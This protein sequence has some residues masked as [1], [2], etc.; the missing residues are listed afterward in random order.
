MK[1]TIVLTLLLTV[2]LSASVY[3][4]NSK[5]NLQLNNATLL[6]LLQSIESNSDYKFFYNNDEI[7]V[8]R[9]VSVNASNIE[10]E[11]ILKEV[12]GNTPYS[13]KMMKNNLILIENTKGA[14]IQAAGQQKTVS[15]KV[16]DSSGQPLP[17]V[18]VV[19]KGTTTGTITDFDG[20]Y[21]LANVPADATLVFSF[22]G[23]K[24]QEISVS[25]KSS[26]QV[27][28]EED[29]VGIEEVVA[30]GY[31]S[32][33]KK[34]LTSSITTVSAEELN[35]G[36]IRDPVLALQ[37]KVPGL[38]ITK[39]GSP[40]GSASI[41]LR[42]VS[43][44]T[45][46]G[47]PFY[48]VDGMPNALMPAMDDIVSI[49]VLKDASATAIYGSRAANGVIIIT[50]KKGESGKQLISYNSYVGVETVSNSIDMMSGLEYRKY[51]ADNGLSINPED[52]M[53]VNTNWQ[54][55]LTRVGISHKNN[56]SI[57]GGTNKTTYISSIEYY[58]NDGV[59]MGTSYDRINMRGSIEQYGFND[60]LKLQ[61]Q[62]GGKIDNS[63]R[64]IDLEAVLRNM[65]IFQPTYAVR[66][67]DGTYA[68]RVSNGPYN[69]VALIEQHEYQTKNRSIF[70][71]IRAD[72]NIMEGLD[73]T[74]N[75]SG[76]NGQSISS[77][78]YSKESRID[79]GSNG[80]A[81]RNAYESQ[82]KA[83]ETYLTYKKK[84]QN[85]NISLLAGYSWQE[86]VSGDG[87]QSSN[88]DFV[89]DDVLYYNLGLGSGNISDYGTTTIATIRMISGYARL[90]YDL[91]D[92]YLFQATIR[93]DGS[94]A[95]GKNARWGTFP[96]A[97][98]GWRLM[99][100]PFIKNLNVFDNL[101][102][103]AGYGTS[104][105]SAGFDPLSSLVRWGGGGYFYKQ[106][107]W[108][109]GITP[110]QNENL[111]LAWERTHM[112]NIGLD[113]AFLKGRISG[114]VEYYNK[115][116][117]GMVW[118]Y[119]V[120]AEK[121]YVNWINANVGEMN[122]KG[123]EFSLNVVPVQTND[124]SWNSSLVMSFNKNEVVSLSNDI[125]QREYIDINGVGQHGQSGNYSHRIQEGYPIGQFCLW[126]YAGENESGISQFVL[127]DG[128]LSINP[129]SLDR[130]ITKENAQPK[131]TGGWS[132]IITYKKF[133]LDFLF[134]GVTGN[135]I[136]NTTRADLNYPAEAGRYNLSKEAINEPINN[137]RSNYTSTRYLEKGDYIR[138]DN[139]TLS[140]APR[141][142]SSF[143][144]KL[145]VYTTVNNAFVLTKYK[146]IDPEISMGGL[147]PGIDDRNFYPKT[148]SFVFGVN[149]D[150]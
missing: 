65:F 93:R 68:E 113:F 21:T 129:S 72:L 50:T 92:K 38:N 108:V 45:L 104:G 117:E 26:L 131:A 69:P 136:L 6:E 94:S 16:T 132:N 36:V 149:V 87:F 73:Y 106:G 34:D 55:E 51:M 102:I 64:L 52:D 32:I 123:W 101:K 43:S 115:T 85:Q 114:T 77:V 140:Y 137:V 61:F 144:K 3:S 139:I 5:M 14:A 84:I 143:L 74:L 110:I 124:F 134:R 39:D 27:S 80:Y 150:F 2:Q 25:G 79:Q 4:Q 29:A 78:Y 120:P 53:G 49:D 122:N 33:L 75:V 97:S 95:F 116:T 10:V 47:T 23:M 109:T 98:V 100:E 90:N 7:D 145:R 70:G 112:L 22:V 54:D 71:N 31:G 99:E 35:K 13:F 125:F 1:L 62:I 12:F 59:I 76:N 9:K 56:L 111:D 128:S 138:L 82:S 83:L 148:R 44:L 81:R 17:G 121:Y 118:Q 133:T 127:A 126:E 119:T 8:S 142:S 57:S 135:Y 15:G 28:M 107:E 103:R 37:G 146:G 30:I 96:S 60:K 130:K 18:S 24:T 105:N 40:Y 86:D 141:I 67:A 20:K 46:S 88:F 89:S 11:A 66:N 42:G 41:T 58:K 19:V 48:I 91:M 63:D 147:Y